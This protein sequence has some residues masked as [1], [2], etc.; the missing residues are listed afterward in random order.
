MVVEWLRLP[1][2]DHSQEIEKMTRLSTIISIVIGLTVLAGAGVTVNAYFAKASELQ[3]VSM[4]LDRKIS[5]DDYN[6][7]QRRVWQ[8][9]DRWRGRTMPQSVREEYRRLKHDLRL[10]EKRLR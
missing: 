9:E 3:M 4:R 8:L 1:M 7:K 10:I 5:Q 6:F 2:P